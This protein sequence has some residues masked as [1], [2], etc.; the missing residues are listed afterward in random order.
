MKLNIRNLFLLSAVLGTSS[1]FSSTT[2]GSLASSSSK[3]SNTQLQAELGRREMMTA[4]A[5]SVGALVV[6]PVEA[7]FAEY[8]PQYK[9]MQQIYCTSWCLMVFV[10]VGVGVGV[11]VVVC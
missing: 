2:G 9:D 6:V 4:A 11:G 8:V 10:G 1:G 5:L 7:A 3:N